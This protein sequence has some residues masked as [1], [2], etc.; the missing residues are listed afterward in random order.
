MEFAAPIVD[1][2][3]HTFYSD[4][5]GTHADNIRAA[6]NAGCRILCATDHLTMEPS[7]FPNDNSGVD[8]ADLP[9]VATDIERA[10]NEVSDVELVFGYECD[11]YEGCEPYVMRYSE[12]ATFRLGSVHYIGD[13]AIDDPD[14]RSLYEELGADGVWKAYAEAWTKAC[15]SS[16]PFDS[17]AHPDLAMRFSRDGWHVS[18]DL[19]DTFRAMA[20]CAHDTHRRVEV[21]TAGIRKGIGTYYPN[22]EL[23]MM[24]HDAEVPITV[25]SDAHRPQDICWNIRGAYAYAY[26]AGYRSFDCPRADGDW[27]TF[28][29]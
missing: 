25:G 22:H 23:L 20:E 14:D 17:M 16:L 4:G 6:R 19:T 10:R 26:S 18:R 3:T 15:E 7:L 5:V 12:G 21:S 1:T 2:H 28:R 24:F 27:T 8:E 11:W 9:K 29:L 13:K